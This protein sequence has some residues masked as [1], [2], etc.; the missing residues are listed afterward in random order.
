M[1]CKNFSDLLVSSE[2]GI[3]STGEH[4]KVNGENIRYD[5]IYFSRVVFRAKRV[6]VRPCANLQIS[7]RTSS[8]FTDDIHNSAVTQLATV[9]PASNR[10][11]FRIALFS[12]P[13]S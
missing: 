9:E 13:P 4:R 10:F 3:T 6:N 7:R 1:E 2:G 8:R 5:A 11:P 12:F